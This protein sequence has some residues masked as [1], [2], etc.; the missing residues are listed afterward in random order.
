MLGVPPLPWMVHLGRTGHGKSIIVWL[1]KQVVLELQQR[2]NRRRR[3][4]STKD[5]E[6]DKKSRG[7]AS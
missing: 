2:V 1:I 5:E 3:R 6:A 4:S 7:R